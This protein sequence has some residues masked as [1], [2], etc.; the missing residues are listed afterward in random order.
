MLVEPD[1]DFIRALSKQGGDLFKKCMQCG[2]CS[3]TCSLSPDS[4]PFPS[5]EMA[6]AAWG[7]KEKLLRDPDVWLCFHC[8]DCSTRCPRGA[9]PGDVLGAIRQESVI[10][11]A[12]PRFLGKWVNKPA[13]IPFLLGIPILL[14]SLAMYLKGPIEN[15][16]NL[17]NFTGERIIFN[18]SNIFPHWLLNSF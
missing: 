18:Y 6:W 11:H 1:L 13:F 14:L 10:Q 5:K 17:T 2:T 8:N 4:K 3:A 15:K 16:L 7:M 9:R 12:F